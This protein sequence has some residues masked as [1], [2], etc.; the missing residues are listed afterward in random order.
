MGC[1]Q[2]VFN[3]HSE[4]L[5]VKRHLGP[6]VQVSPL[7]LGG[8]DSSKGVW[9]VFEVLSF[10]ELYDANPDWMNM[11]QI[12]WRWVEYCLLLEVDEVLCRGVKIQGLSN[13]NLCALYLIKLRFICQNHYLYK[14]RVCQFA[15]TRS[16][17]LRFCRRTHLISSHN[18][19]SSVSMFKK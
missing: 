4:K 2:S 18:E 7:D 9:D 5:F 13:S 19:Y 11:T 15:M 1:K 14:Y 6:G 10:H 8:K 12:S 17:I 3:G 16:I